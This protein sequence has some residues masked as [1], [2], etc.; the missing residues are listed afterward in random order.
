MNI[1]EMTKNDFNNLPIIEADK[2]ENVDS[3]V[4]LPTDK[5]WEEGNYL[6]FNIVPCVKDEPLGKLKKYDVFRN[7]KGINEF[8][9][10]ILGTSKLTRMFFWNKYDIIPWA[11]LIEKHREE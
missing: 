11:H 9:I 10:D 2:I 6:Y 3:I 5:K 8:T 1:H 7:S 4:I